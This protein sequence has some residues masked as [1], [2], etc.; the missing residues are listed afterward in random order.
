M[1]KKQSEIMIT[2]DDILAFN[3]CARYNSATKLLKYSGGKASVSLKEFLA[4]DIPWTVKTYCV[5]NV[6]II[7]Q[8]QIAAIRNFIESRILIVK[9]G[10]DSRADKKLPVSISFLVLTELSAKE[11]VTTKQKRLLI[12]NESQRI[13]ERIL[14]LAEIT[15]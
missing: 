14:A 8:N 10:S 2:I 13:L 1:P 7:P 11:K 3:P 12:D 6:G 4:F 9:R 15:P 5:L